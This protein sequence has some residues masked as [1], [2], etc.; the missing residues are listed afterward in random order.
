MK[1]SILIAFALGA[2]LIVSAQSQSDDLSTLKKQVTVLKNKNLKLE[3]SIH[4]LKVAANTQSKNMDATLKNFESKLIANTD[5][6][7]KKE[8]IIE[9]NRK[10]A[11]VLY[12]S[13]QHRKKLF[14]TGFIIGIILLAV[15]A[16]LIGKKYKADLKKQESLAAEVKQS[17]EEKL[18]KTQ[19]E[20]QAQIVSV[21]DALEK[22]INDLKK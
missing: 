19:N 5:S 21:K 12:Q 13:L 15:S 9:T 22:K 14:I 8:K 3:K 11:Y 7:Q 18:I 2:F 16:F 1:K 10:V 4:E 20:F 17:L 6:L